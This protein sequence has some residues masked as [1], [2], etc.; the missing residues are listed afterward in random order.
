MS[1]M[2]AN[3]R[4]FPQKTGSVLPVTWGIICASYDVRFVVWHSVRA[5]FPRFWVDHNTWWVIFRFV[6]GLAQVGLARFAPFLRILLETCVEMGFVAPLTGML[7]TQPCCIYG[8]ASYSRRTEPS[9]TP[10]WKQN[11]LRH[12]FGAACRPRNVCWTAVECQLW[13]LF[14]VAVKRRGHFLATFCTAVFICYTWKN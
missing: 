6:I 7:C 14:L 13:S 10:L 4:M 2:S 1:E 9:A 3:V 12:L 11:C 5:A 8:T